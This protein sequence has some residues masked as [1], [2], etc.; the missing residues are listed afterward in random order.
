MFDV[1]INSDASVVLPGDS[2][3][4]LHFE[5][6]VTSVHQASPMSLRVFQQKQPY[7]MQS[8]S[9]LK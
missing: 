4:A 9:I 5:K 2:H 1:F 7:N 8:K 6:K 3:D